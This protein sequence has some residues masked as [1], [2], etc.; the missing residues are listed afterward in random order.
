MCAALFA[1]GLEGELEEPAPP[2]SH[3]KPEPITEE[4]FTELNS[5]S[6]FLRPLDLSN[7]LVL[8]GLA[9]VDGEVYATLHDPE[10]KKTHFVS[11]STNEMGWKIVGIEGDQS[12]LTS[13]R[14]LISMTGGEV[15]T[16]RY[17]ETQLKPN[18]Q[19]AG[20][21]SRDGRSG[22]DRSRYDRDPRDYREGI[23]GDGFRGRPPKEL[24]DK[25]S[26][27]SESDR[28]RVIQQIREIRDRSPDIS[29]EQRQEIF[30]RMVDRAL[31]NR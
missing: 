4:D 2:Q 20:G 22:G 6:P 29:S 3:W 8:T 11:S 26:R 15:F 25:L 7:S 30:T 31:Q 14:A 9:R 17:T 1:N 18:A 24:V 12:D 27:L 13:V 16:V 21:S 28:N 19:S 23:S 10:A 5:N